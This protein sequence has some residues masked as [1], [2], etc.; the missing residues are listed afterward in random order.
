MHRVRCIHRHLSAD[1]S[2]QK[3]HRQVDAAVIFVDAEGGRSYPLRS[4]A[5]L[6]QRA[7]NGVS[8]FKRDDGGDE[9]LMQTVAECSAQVL[10]RANQR[11]AAEAQAAARYIPYIE[12]CHV[13]CTADAVSRL[14]LGLNIDVRTRSQFRRVVQ[15]IGVESSYNVLDMADGAR[16]EDGVYLGDF[17]V[18]R[19]NENRENIYTTDIFVTADDR[20]T[21]AGDGSGTT[22]TS[23]RR[24]IHMG[25]DLFDKAGT[26]VHAFYDGEVWLTGHYPGAG[27]YGFVVV[28]RHVL[29]VSSP[30]TH[31]HLQHVVVW[32][33]HG[34]LE[35]ESVRG[36]QV[37][38]RVAAGE[39]IG[40]IGRAH[41][42]VN[43]GWV[44]HLH[45]QLTTLEP[46]LADW[47]GVV[48]KQHREAACRIYPDPRQVLGQLW[49]GSDGHC[50]GHR[51][52]VS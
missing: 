27:D 43:G 38:Q 14:P 40:W 31:E 23:T 11:A 18:G 30:G 2:L 13:G 25:C 28:L 7:V 4:A 36:K 26:P 21:T 9:R 22:A 6:K 24:T 3:E 39:V 32:S 44:P 5:L 47:P 37:G 20:Q 19:W 41:T 50:E 10:D 17:A 46:R 52:R 51:K 33:L 15:S 42:D 1:P 29:P 35:P 49:L 48:A 8:E 34:H 16:I 12:R 45:F